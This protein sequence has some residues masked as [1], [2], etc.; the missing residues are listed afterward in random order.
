[1]AINIELW[2][3][4]RKELNL[5]YR[6]LAQKADVSLNTIKNIFRGA[7]TDPRIETVQ[8]IERALGIDE[9]EKSSP[10]EMSESEKLM[11]ELFNRIPDE[12]QELVLEM[13]RAALN[14]LD[15]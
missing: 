10:T 2:K 5:D 1:M 9:K 13:I 14:N 11:L 3:Q 15:N 8:A 7:T 12:H 4:K 6:M